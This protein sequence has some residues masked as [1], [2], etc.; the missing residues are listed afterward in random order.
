[1]ILPEFF[2]S[3]FLLRESHFLYL[4][5]FAPLLYAVALMKC[6]V[7]LCASQEN[8]MNSTFNNA[9]TRISYSFFS[10]AALFNEIENL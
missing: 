6:L 1:M 8:L 10:P 5:Q 3:F 9:T 2:F 4:F 7:F